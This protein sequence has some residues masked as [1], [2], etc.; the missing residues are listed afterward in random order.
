MAIQD[1]IPKSRGTIRYRT[2]ITGIPEDRELPF[3]LLFVG[4]FSGEK[5]GEEDKY[6]VKSDLENRTIHG[7]TGNNTDAVMR[8]LKIIANNIQIHSMDDLSPENATKGSDEIYDLVQKRLVLNSIL[9]SLSNSKLFRERLIDVILESDEDL[10][11]DINADGKNGENVY[12]YLGPLKRDTGGT[13][14]PDNPNPPVDP[15]PQPEPEPPAE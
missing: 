8:K 5:G 6:G 4:D 10:K 1:I 7:L 14:N 12:T 2:N 13:D 3:R 15:D 11:A 9:S